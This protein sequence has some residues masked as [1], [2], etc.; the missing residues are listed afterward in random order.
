M[1]L[2]KT[3]NV[4]KRNLAAHAAYSE[5]CMDFSFAAE[6]QFAERPGSSRRK[7]VEHAEMD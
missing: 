6:R 2:Q 3:I 5:S 7:D 4:T 1:K